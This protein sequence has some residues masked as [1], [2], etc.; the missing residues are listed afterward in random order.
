VPVLR[1][2]MILGFDAP[3]DGITTDGLIATVIAAIKSTTK[4]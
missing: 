4:A 2:R 3:L 1:H